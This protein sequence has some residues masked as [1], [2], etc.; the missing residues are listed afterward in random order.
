MRFWIYGFWFGP[1]RSTDDLSMGE[2]V[3]EIPFCRK[4]NGEKYGEV[5]AAWIFI[6]FNN[7]ARYTLT[8]ICILPRINGTRVWQS[9]GT[10]THTHTHAYTS[11]CQ[12]RPTSAPSGKI[13]SRIRIC[14]VAFVAQL[15]TLSRETFQRSVRYMP[16]RVIE[17]SA[18]SS[19]LHVY[20]DLPKICEFSVISIR[21]IRHF[22]DILIVTRRFN[23]NLFILTIEYM[24]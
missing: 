16:C 2:T 24:R 20:I 13:S 15:N 12:Q 11:W 1:M 23:H 21:S 17:R 6:D 10:K 8:N 14:I 4:Q 3:R 19:H 18:I 5:E 7:C 22:C 9:V